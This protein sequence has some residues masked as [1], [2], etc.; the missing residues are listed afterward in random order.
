MEVYLLYELLLECVRLFQKS[1]S[2]LVK[3]SSNVVLLSVCCKRDAFG[4][5][6]V[7]WNAVE[8]KLVFTGEVGLHEP[9]HHSH[10][11]SR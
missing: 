1:V 8:I 6:V 4:I 9:D 7:E 2:F 10:I 11:V 5:V 3:G